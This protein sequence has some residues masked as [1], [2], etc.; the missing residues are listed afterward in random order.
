[1]AVQFWNSPFEDQSL[2]DFASTTPVAQLQLVAMS[3]GAAAI[4]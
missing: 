1:M 4:L 3:A 2:V